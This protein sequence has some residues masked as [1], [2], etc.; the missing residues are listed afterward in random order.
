MAVAVGLDALPLDL[1]PLVLGHLRYRVNDLW[2]CCLTSRL[3][4]ELST[5]LL[6]ER[7]WLRDQRRLQRVFRTL[8]RNHRLCR[9]VR[10][11]E[12]RVFPFGLTSEL[13]E[14]L[15]TAIEVTFRHAVHLRELAWTR[16]GS[17][18]DR[19]L[20]Y[21][22]GSAERLTRVELTGDA[23]TWSTQA[24]LAY[25]P[26]SVQHLSIILPERTVVNALVD[27]ASKLAAQPISGN[28]NG[29]GDGGGLR[30]LSLLCQ[31]SPLV[32]D[33]HLQAMAPYLHRLQR[34]SL[35]GC[36]A[37]TGKGVHA[38]LRSSGSSS[39]AAAAR[40]G[41]TGVTNLAL[42]GLDIQGKDLQLLAPFAAQLRTLSITYPR[43]ASSSGSR[44]LPASAL[45]EFYRHFAEMIEQAV[46][47][48]ELTHYAGAGSRPALGGGNDDGLGDDEGF[49]DLE[50]LDLDDD[51]GEEDDQVDALGN[52][53]M[54][55]VDGSMLAGF[56]ATTTVEDLVRRFSGP[57]PGS[58]RYGHR[59]ASQPPTN[60]PLCSTYFLS[61]LVAARG[62]HLTQL[63]LHGMGTSLDQLQLIVHGCS[64][65]CDLVIQIWEDDLSRLAALLCQL[66][67]LESVHLLASASSDTALG[68]EEIRWIAQMCADASR[69]RRQRQ[70]QQ[71]SSNPSR[72]PPSPLGKGLQQIGFRNR[73]W[74][75]DHTAAQSEP[76]STRGT[77]PA[78][79]T[80]K[81]TT[82]S[83]VTLKR[84]DMSAGTFPE[85]LL[86]VRS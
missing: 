84:W 15:E 43:S 5:P 48:H 25:I 64:A 83:H 86:V 40:N 31:H 8:A 77:M 82:S 71:R 66:P 9:F 73:V 35:A 21:L 69:D 39:T 61:R 20:P 59:Q 55:S 6:Y 75:V 23:R 56:Q 78:D 81:H 2:A 10:T 57:P 19:L 12:L 32:K 37:V 45:H 58:V 28:N 51:D 44:S 29:S 80:G 3:F 54:S 41:H 42:E 63:R 53:A 47:L 52:T 50:D 24:L 13:L 62:Q 4:N 38:I 76:A 30:S 22:L 74:L 46:N 26:A 34:L 79:D 33:A 16:T 17:L 72:N 49:V 60:L 67:H 18:N 68:E 1:I 7:L 27:I 70:G 36:R 11:V 65:L 85:V 14:A